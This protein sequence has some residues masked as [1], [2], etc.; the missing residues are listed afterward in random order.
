MFDSGRLESAFADIEER[1]VLLKS[2]E[3]LRNVKTGKARRKA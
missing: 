1:R 3:A 2:E